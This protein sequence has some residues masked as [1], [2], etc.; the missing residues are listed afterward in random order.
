MFT[1]LMLLQSIDPALVESFQMQ[2]PEE[3]S[4]GAVGWK[5]FSAYF[6]ALGNCLY[7]SFVFMTV[8]KSLIVPQVCDMA[9]STISPTWGGFLNL[10]TTCYIGASLQVSEV[11]WYFYVSLVM[12]MNLFCFVYLWSKMI[13]ACLHEG[14]GKLLNV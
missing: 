12:W 5:I 4:H 6:Q 3:R 1:F 7:V 11:E 10:G 8:I 9:S 14:N 13:V 2:E